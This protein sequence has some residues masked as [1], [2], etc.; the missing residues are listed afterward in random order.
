MY[1]EI[2][3]YSLETGRY[4]P[5]QRLLTRGAVRFRHFSWGEGVEAEHFLVVANQADRGEDCVPYF[6]KR[7]LDELGKLIVMDCLS[8]S[9]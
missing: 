6:G 9:L 3:R 2:L 4:R 5:Y 1:S 8:L 7:A